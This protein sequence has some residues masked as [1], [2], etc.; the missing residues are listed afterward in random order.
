MQYALSYFTEISKYIIIATVAVY[1]LTGFVMLFAG[2]GRLQKGLGFFQCF[3]IFAVQAVE[4]LHLTVVSGNQNYIFFYLFLQLILLA[5]I[6]LMHI[7][8][9]KEHP[10]LLNNMCMLLGFGFCMIS[11]LNFG[12]AVRQLVIVGITFAIC[13]FV[14]G[15]LKKLHFWRRLTWVYAVVGVSALSTVLILGEVYGGS[16]IS[17]T[18]ADTITFQPSEFVKILFLFFLAGALW[19]EHHFWNVALT[20]V[21]AGIH[22]IILVVST[23]LGSALIFFV[24]YVI[25]VF[26]TTRNYLYLFPGILGGGLAATVAYRF[27]G[28]VRI[29]VLAWQDP[30]SYID[31]EGYQITQSLFAIGSGNWFGMGLLRGNPKAIPL[32]DRDFIFSCVCEEM[33]VITGICLALICLLSFLA[34]SEI[35]VKVRDPFYQLIVY[36]IAV[37]YLFQIFLTVGGGIKFIPMTGVTLPFVSYGGSSVMTSI[38][39]FFIVQGVWLML[40]QEGGE[41]NA[42]ERAGSRQ[43]Q[44]G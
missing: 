1:T 38:F 15:L 19:E 43:S 3:L 29:R 11:R 6:G 27:F 32:V 41:G 34:M 2:R 23:D 13:I 16:R 10:I 28:H 25:I 26:V 20:A 39:M 18:I 9:E 36:G 22:V 40:Q 21:V 4:F 42:G 7:L 12:K 35:A 37:V 24:A 17:F 14:P 33:G 44:R 5:V 30:W 8:Y 31:K